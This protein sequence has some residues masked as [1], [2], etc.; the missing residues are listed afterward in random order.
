MNK[1]LRTIAGAIVIAATTGFSVA[2][3]TGPPSV[4]QQEQN[5]QTADTASLEQSQPIPH[6]SYS[7]IRQTAIDAE[8][9]AADGAQTTSFFF[10]MGARD[11]V[12]SCPSLGMPVPVTA[13]LSNPEQVVPVTGRWGGGH[14]TLPQMD[15]DGI[16]APPS[17][18]GTNVIC[19]NSSGAKYL[20][21]WEGDVLTVTAGATWDDVTHTLKVTG[22]PTAVI[23]T[24]PG[25]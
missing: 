4:Q 21:Y 11:P 6:Y 20:M 24:G 2:A 5:A 16:Y 17:S 7:Q 19:V 14:D 23:H 10:Q 3:C 22:A 1:N 13:Q 8:T 12:Y 15:P 25:K 18:S 9:I